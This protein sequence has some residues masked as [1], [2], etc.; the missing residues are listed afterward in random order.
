MNQ[1]ELL[2]ISVTFFLT[3]V[4]WVLLDIYRV[5]KNIVIKDKIRKIQ[6]VTFSIDADAVRRLKQRTP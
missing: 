5:N 4:S 3:I 6:P 2:I 1:K